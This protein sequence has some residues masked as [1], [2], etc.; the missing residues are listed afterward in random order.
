MNMSTFAQNVHAVIS[1]PFVNSEIFVC[2][3]F[4]IFVQKSFAMYHFF[5]SS[6]VIKGLDLFKSH[7]CFITRLP[8]FDLSRLEKESETWTSP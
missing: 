8:R 4:V 5:S 6:L 2:S 1:L 3:G 7:I